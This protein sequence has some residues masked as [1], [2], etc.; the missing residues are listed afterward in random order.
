LGGGD[1]HVHVLPHQVGGHLG[2]AVEVAFRPAIL[3]EDVLALD[4]TQFSQAIRKRRDDV[5][6]RRRCRGHQQPNTA[7]LR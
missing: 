3:E 1:E 6:G 5:C 2:E 7:R 4:V